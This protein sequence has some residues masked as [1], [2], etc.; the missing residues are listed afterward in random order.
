MIVA[1]A[2]ET[3]GSQVVQQNGIQCFNC[4]EFRH[5]AKEY[6]KPKRVKDYTYYKEKMLLCKQAEKAD[7]RNDVEP[8]E[9]VQYDDEYNVFAN[10]MQHSEQLEYINDTHVLEKDDSNV[11]PDSSNMCNND[12]QVDQNVMECD[13]ERAALANLIEN[14]TLDTEENKKILK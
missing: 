1:G 5:F 13:D 11:T 12:Y 14:L 6:K 10:E 8:L 3:I 4:K 9:H 7:S 2:R